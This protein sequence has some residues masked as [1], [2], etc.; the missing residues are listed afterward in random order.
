MFQGSKDSIRKNY[1]DFGFVPKDYDYLLLTH[2]H[3]DHCGRIPK[4]V[5]EGFKG[6][7]YCT[8]ATKELAFVVFMDAAKIAKED[9]YHE[10]KRRAKEGLPERKPIYNNADVKNAMNLFITTDYNKEV[11]I[12]DNFSA[13]FFDAGH[14]LGASSVQLHI[15]EKDKLKRVV[16]SG[17]LGQEKSILMKGIQPIFEADYVFMESTYGDRVH[18]DA[19]QK[20]KELIRVINETY[21][22]G[23]KLMIPAFAV[24]RA[25]EVIYYIGEFMSRGLIPKMKVFLDS[26]M[27]IKATEIFKKYL[28]YYNE[29]FR[30]SAKK[31]N[32][33]DFPQLILTSTM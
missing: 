32:P 31:R 19:S 25:Q 26:P 14:I 16:F 24:E 9:T 8:Q 12:S 29:E 13:I 2:A 33:F 11:K 28:E 22:K 7:I 10:N 15:K 3:F 21:A 5:K 27:A 20:K 6:K 1:E 4:L 18:P 30:A 17:D 23:G